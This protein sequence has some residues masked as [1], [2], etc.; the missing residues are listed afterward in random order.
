[1]KDKK[2]S[3]RDAVRRRAEAREFTSGGGGKFLLPRS[4]IQFYTPG[5][6]TNEI[7]IVPYIVTVNNHEYAQKGDEW[8]QKTILVHFGVGVEEKSYICPRT[9]SKPC[10]ICEARA[11]MLKDADA[12]EAV[13]ASLK[14]KEREIYNVIDLADKDKG[15]QFWEIS[16]H[17]FGKMLE[18]EIRESDSELGYSAFAGTRN[19]YTL[20]VRF[21]EETIGKNTFLK[22]SRIDF[23]ERK[24]YG[25][26]I[27]D[28]T[29][30]LDSILKVLSYDALEK[31][32]LG[33]DANEERPD[34]DAGIADE[35]IKKGSKEED[36]DIPIG[37]E[38]KSRVLD[39][40]RGS[41][42]RRNVEEDVREER[43]GRGV[44]CERSSGRRHI[45]EDVVE[46]KDKKRGSER[47]DS[48][49]EEGEEKSRGSRSSSIK[50][51]AGGSFGTDCD[52]LEDCDTCDI[53]HDC[54]EAY[55]S[56]KKDR[57]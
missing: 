22:A 27:L 2:N 30:N 6:K 1:M 31:I 39:E 10:P 50:C 13:T 36:D 41:G 24:D 38:K 43:G 54:R 46:D 35:G 14:P 48:K 34:E 5:K 29:L 40:E 28:K 33:L 21:I 15:V 52:A 3:L 8:Y 47:K 19:G 45:E 25:E 11:K 20:K 42:R 53:W 55:D 17:N 51:P 44:E 9:V 32:Y 49:R 7:D 23:V 18:E 12:D 56:K 37:D 57:R 26:S 4:D 16:F